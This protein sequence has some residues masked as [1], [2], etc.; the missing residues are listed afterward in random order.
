MKIRAVQF[1]EFAYGDKR[2][3]RASVKRILDDIEKDYDPATDRY[4]KFRESL[5]AYEDGTVNEGEFLNFYKIVAANKSE[6]YKVL[7]KNY[8]D[9]KDDHGLIWD[10]L[11][12]VSAKLGK[13]EV[14]ASWYLH[15]DA[16]N[17]RRIVFLNF[18][19]EP[20]S[21]QHE[22]GLFTLLQIAAPESAGV[23]I[24]NVQFATLNVSSRLD[25]SELVFLESRA[26]KFVSIAE[27]L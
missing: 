9:A 6:A 18:R 12:R 10:G 11:Q 26:A 15:T 8:V 20:F 5:G 7:A 3:D 25:E 4:K 27:T 22:K 13:L 17:Q 14:T 21:H 1:I 16:S 23:G 24:L 19:K 2:R